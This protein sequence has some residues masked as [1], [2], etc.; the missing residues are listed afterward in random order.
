MIAC[1]ACGTRT[2]VRETR[3]V[4]AALRR[5]RECPKC[6]HGVTTLEVVVARSSVRPGGDV[7]VI[8]RRKLAE[9]RALIAAIAPA[10]L[11]EEEAKT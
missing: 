7:V 9:L 11:V 6:K 4:G 5:R 3:A 8:P 2:G 10:D 1:P